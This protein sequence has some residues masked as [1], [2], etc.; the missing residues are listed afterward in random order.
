MMRGWTVYPLIGIGVLA[1]IIGM[2]V[3]PTAYV[4]ESP[5]LVPGIFI[6]M[7]VFFA[8]ISTLVIYL[9]SPRLIIPGANF[10]LSQG[11][12]LKTVKVANFD[13]NPGLELYH[14]FALNGTPIGPLAGGGK[15]GHAVFPAQFDMNLLGQHSANVVWNVYRR[16]PNKRRGEMPLD[17]V[18]KPILDALRE[19]TTWNEDGPVWFGRIPLIPPDKIV[20]KNIDLKDEV[21]LLNA[22]NKAVM[23][24][25]AKLRTTVSEQNSVIRDLISSFPGMISEKLKGRFD[26]LRG[27][28]GGGMEGGG[29]QGG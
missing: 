6:M 17:F 8:V 16:I 4:Q 10:T 3:L 22:Q 27:G 26:W 20:I 25:N 21:D 2:A 12:P 13:K 28:G 7:V 9:K 15:E 14:I 23:D 11:E 24:Q 18:P 1:W 29:E 5:L 19:L